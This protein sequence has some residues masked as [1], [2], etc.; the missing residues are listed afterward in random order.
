MG[1]VSFW[2][3]EKH[4]G[5]RLRWWLLNL[6]SELETA[7]AYIFLNGGF[8][9]FWILSWFIKRVLFEIKNII[10]EV[11][12]SIEDLKD[13]V[14]E[15]SQK[16][17]QIDK[18]GK[19]IKMKWQDYEAQ[20]PSNRNSRKREKEKVERG[21]VPNSMPV[22]SVKILLEHRESKQI[23]MKAYCYDSRDTAEY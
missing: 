10:E 2:N 13:K 15:M 14:E 7:A 21:K 19:C 18:G 3:D 22:S 1:R 12:S 5:I 20:N 23:H 8:Y 6:A 11:K 16:V 17:K 4:S 9:G